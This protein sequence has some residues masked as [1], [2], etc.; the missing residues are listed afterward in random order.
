MASK[1]QENSVKAILQICAESDCKLATTGGLARR[2]GISD[3]TA[4][5]LIRSLGEAGLVEFAPYGG[6]RL[7]GRGRRMALK[8][9][10]RHRL[11]ELFLATVLEMDWHEVHAE[12]ERLEH[13]VSDAL[14][15]RIDKF[16]GHPKADPHGDPIPRSDG[17]LPRLAMLPLDQCETGMRFAVAR[18]LDQSSQVLKYLSN[19]GLRVDA[20][21]RVVRKST[22][23]GIVSIELGG[24]LLSISQA[25]A[26]RILVASP[27]AKQAAK[28]N[29]RAGSLSRARR[30]TA[31][32]RDRH[33]KAGKL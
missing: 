33:G 26:A 31:P 25:V 3:G 19:V 7:S 10:R 13:A 1:T 24:E 27:S 9:V 4:S 15:E 12:A 30:L 17:T 29:G 18:V 2:L 23:A 22:A 16:L 11:I 28:K 21:G 8:V 6:A 5:K 14:A 32:A 20:R